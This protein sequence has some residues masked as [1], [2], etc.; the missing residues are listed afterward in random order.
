MSSS[1]D[2]FFIVFVVFFCARQNF[3]FFFFLFFFFFFFFFWFGGCAWGGE[4]GKKMVCP[5]VLIIQSFSAKPRSSLSVKGF[6]NPMVSA[7][8][9]KT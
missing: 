2:P 5:D 1:A 6:S 7:M 3:S 8:C 4:R 9:Q